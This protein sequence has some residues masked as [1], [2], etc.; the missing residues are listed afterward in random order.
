MFGCHNNKCRSYFEGEKFVSVTDHS[1]LRWLMETN[2]R[3]KEKNSW[4]VNPIASCECL[5]WHDNRASGWK[6]MEFPDAMSRS[7]NLFEV[8]T[9]TTDG[10]YNKMLSRAKDSNLDEYKIVDN[11]L[12]H[13][14]KFCSYS[15]VPI[16]KIIIMS[17]LNIVHSPLADQAITN[18]IKQLIIL[19]WFIQ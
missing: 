10:W 17:V 4:M 6:K 3:K 19:K 16:T 5:W 12:Y 15:A 13:L 18:A 8:N 7:I 1:A 2:E 11:K 14:N 9:N